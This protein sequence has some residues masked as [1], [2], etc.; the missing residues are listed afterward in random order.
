[1]RSRSA[2]SPMRAEANP[3]P[4]SAMAMI[5][6]RALGLTATNVPL[7]IVPIGARA[8]ILVR[9]RT[10]MARSARSSRVATARI[11][12]AMIVAAKSVR[13]HRAVIDPISTAMIARRA[14]TA[15]TMP[16]R[17]RASRTR[18]SATRNPTPRAAKVSRKMVTGPVAIVPSARG[19]RAM[20]TGL[21]EIGPS[22]NSVATRSSRHAVRRIVVRARISEVARI[23]AATGIAGGDRDRGPRK[24]FGF[25]PR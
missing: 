14:V 24:D 11:S 12:A 19:L 13:T 17:P 20:A 8:R 7:V 1:V 16:V 15:A 9:V 23:A 18:S 5:A 2:R 10:V 4:A 22:E 6:R 3:T 25:R 21:V